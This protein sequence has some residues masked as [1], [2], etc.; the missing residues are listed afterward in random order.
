MCASISPDLC[1]CIA[2]TDP[3]VGIS[4]LRLQPIKTSQTLFCAKSPKSDRRV[5]RKTGGCLPKPVQISNGTRSSLPQDISY[6]QMHQS[7]FIGTLESDLVH[8]IV[9]HRVVGSKV[10]GIITAPLVHRT[11]SPYYDHPQCLRS[12]QNSSNEVLE[13]VWMPP[14]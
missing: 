4:T 1:P 5:S 8:R 2:R 14:R 7:T 6:N 3:L 13:Y 9:H 12:L 11:E 10:F